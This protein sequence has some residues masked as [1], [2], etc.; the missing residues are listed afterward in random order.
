MLPQLTGANP[1]PSMFGD[2]THANSGQGLGPTPEEMEFERQRVLAMKTV[3]V[4]GHHVRVFD[5]SD[6]EDVAAYEKL[7]MTLIKGTQAR[8]HQ[9]W[10]NEKQLVT[11]GTNQTWMRYME[12]SEFELNVQPTMPVGTN[13]RRK[14]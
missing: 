14:E 6:A 3:N 4:K 11:K 7:M 8:T 13:R 1:G 9:V 10:D 12:W 5:M 2:L